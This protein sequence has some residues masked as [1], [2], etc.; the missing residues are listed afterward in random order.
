MNGAAKTDE[1]TLPV[2]VSLVCS[3]PYSYGILFHETVFSI[4]F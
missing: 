2:P 4:L 1:T 3:R